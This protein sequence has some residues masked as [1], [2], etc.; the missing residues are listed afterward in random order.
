MPLPY[1]QSRTSASS[2][3]SLPDLKGESSSR[4]LGYYLNIAGC[5]GTKEGARGGEEERRHHGTQAER[6]RQDQDEARDGVRSPLG[7]NQRARGDDLRALG[8]S[9]FRSF[10]GSV[11]M[12]AGSDSSNLSLFSF[13]SSTELKVPFAHVILPESTGKSVGSTSTQ[14]SAAYRPGPFFSQ[15]QQSS[16]SRA[17]S[18]AAYPSLPAGAVGPGSTF[19]QNIRQT[20]NPSFQ[21]RPM[22]SSSHSSSSG[23]SYGSAFDA[24]QTPSIAFPS[25]PSTFSAAY[26]S[27]ASRPSFSSQYQQQQQQRPQHPP[28]YQ[29]QNQNTLH[30]PQQQEMRYL[31][32]PHQ[33]S[34]PQH[35]PHHQNPHLYTNFSQQPYTPPTFMYPMTIPSNMAA[36]SFAP[37]PVMLPQDMRLSPAMLELIGKNSVIGSAFANLGWSPAVPAGGVGHA[38]GK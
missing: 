23:P 22:P 36:A 12:L 5:Q 15:T 7:P 21:Q 8:V 16:S 18:S 13:L 34:R 4:L 24:R 2:R 30:Y 37:P 33:Q 27:M 9:R 10:Q 1:S 19:F 38:Q 26:S 31:P 17:P 3:P 25:R 14:P 29:N 11:L 35:P 28:S 6:A 32:P 20:S